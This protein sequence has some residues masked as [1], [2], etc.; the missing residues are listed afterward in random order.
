MSV[1]VIG[2]SGYLG[3]YVTAELLDRGREV[4]AFDLDPAAELRE[5]AEEAAS[6]SVVRGDMTSFADVAD[7]ITAHDAD[8][9]I[10]L[11]YYGTPT[12]GL[13]DAAEQEPYRASN[14]NV[15]G[16]NNVAE[17]ARQLDVETV[18]SASSTVVYGPPSF[19]EALGVETVDED[20]PTAP[21]SLYGAC[22]VLNEHVAEMYREGYG[23]D[24]ACLRLPLVY[25]PQR[26]P[27]AQPFVVE[28]FETAAAGG[29]ITLDGGDST[30]DLLYER[31]VG[32]LFADVLAAGSYDHTAYN[33]VG[34]TVTVRELAAL[35]EE[36]G[37]PDAD[38]DVRPGDDA[39]LPA[40]LD[41]SRLR[42]ELGFEPGYDAE[43]AVADYLET[44]M[45]DGE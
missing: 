31:D 44:L 26:Y 32:P 6:L 38:V 13:L 4:V 24:I 35:A 20:S 28:L 37:D 42:S 41:D 45:D 5:R 34:H 10:Q 29:D 36:Y 17:S 43:S 23:L 40:P 9:V 11:A 21:E 15:T 30:W 2:A 18:V 8:E 39:P 7:A 14:A 27:G 22:K 16:F 1:V 3:R 33:V 19:Y 25:G 12:T